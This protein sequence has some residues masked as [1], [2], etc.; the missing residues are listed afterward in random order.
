LIPSYSNPY[1]ALALPQLFSSLFTEEDNWLDFKAPFESALSRSLP[2]PS[3]SID[4]IE[5]DKK[6]IVS[7]HLPG[8]NKSDIKVRLN[9]S[10]THV[11]ISAE[12][13]HEHKEEKDRYHYTESYY[14][15]IKRTIAIPK[16]ADPSKVDCSYQ[17][18]VLEVSFDK[19]SASAEDFHEIKIN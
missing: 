16:Q 15:T 8:V 3:S 12:R 7:A 11:T 5:K 10:K 1:M 6:F 18:G 17:N 13:K 9:P 14:G 4:V 2:M 19:K